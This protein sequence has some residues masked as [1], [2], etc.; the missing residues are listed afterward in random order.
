MVEKTLHTEF[1][2]VRR[3][4]GCCRD[5]ARGP[6]NSGDAGGETPRKEYQLNVSGGSAA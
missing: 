5:V 6:S 2:I 1:S 4:A 3:V